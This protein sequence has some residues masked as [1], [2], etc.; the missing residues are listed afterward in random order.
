MEDRRARIHLVLRHDGV[1]N[2]RGEPVDASVTQ[3]DLHD[4]CRL[5]LTY[6][7]G[8]FHCVTALPSQHRISGEILDF[9]QKGYGREYNPD[10]TQ[11]LASLHLHSDFEEVLRWVGE[12]E[13]QPPIILGTSARTREKTL[14]FASVSSI[15]W[16][17]GRPVVLQFGT[18][19]GLSEPQLNRCD[20]VL[21]PIQG[22]DGYNHLSVRCA[23]AIIIDR[24]VHSVRIDTI[25]DDL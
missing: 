24:F 18:A 16:R 6:G 9:W 12:K 15:I 22:Y 23:A 4:F 5:C 25:G 8:G 7:L 1:N 21:P 2:R 10:R 20:W 13:G 11:A 3:V 19:W 14:D 17:L